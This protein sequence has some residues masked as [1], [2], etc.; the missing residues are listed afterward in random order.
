MVL[1]T[2]KNRF[3]G[4]G[5]LI[6]LF[7]SFSSCT[8]LSKAKHLHN[9]REYAELAVF[10][11]FCKSEDNGCN[12]LHLLKG[13]ACFRIVKNTSDSQAELTV[14]DCAANELT[15][16]IE[17]T[18][19]WDDVPIDPIKIFENACEA[20]RL[21]ADF[22]E[23]TRYESMLSA[24]AKKFL[25]FAPNFPGA[26]YYNARADF[27]M[28]K[29]SQNPCNALQ[30]LHARMRSALQH[31]KTDNRYSEPYQLLMRTVAVEQEMRCNN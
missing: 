8:S 24:N 23:R 29:Q 21:R 3:A 4:I 20:T 18:K 6:I 22:G 19:A 31:I 17:M 30:T 5:V 28:L 2:N 15:T 16:G 9:D 13:D 14:L 1:P 25:N 12:Q 11:F 10:E 26:I 7:F 27:Y